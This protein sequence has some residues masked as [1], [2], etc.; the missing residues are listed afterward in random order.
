MTPDE[1]FRIAK[2]GMWSVRSVPYKFSALSPVGNIEKSKD[3]FKYAISGVGL[4][5]VIIETP[6]H[7]MTTALLPVEQVYDILLTYQNRMLAFYSDPRIEHVIIFKN[8]GVGAGTSLEHPHS[9]IVGIPVFPGQVMGRLGEAIRNY[10][11]VNFG[12]CLYCTY[13]KGELRDGSRIVAEN[14]SFVAFV[15]Y[16]ALS[17]FHLW[18]FPR[19]HDACFASI[20]E[21]QLLD[22]SYILKDILLRLYKGLDNPDFNYMIRSLSPRG[23]DSKYFHWYIAIVPRVSQAAGFELGTGMFIN[24]ALPEE[25]ARFLREAI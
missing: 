10:Y 5:E 4:H 23:A 14:D 24:T 22:L 18:I 2:N 21:K 7:N 11:Y 3:D 15:P 17:P 6:Q 1:T 9:Q 13:L 19:K 20:D 8:H 16:A 12:E 25:S